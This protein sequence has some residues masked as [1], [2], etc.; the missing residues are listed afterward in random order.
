MAEY[1]ADTI[2]FE[3]APT[4]IRVDPSLNL[5]FGS[6]AGANTQ[7]SPSGL[8]YPFP[9]ENR[10]S[11]DRNGNG[12]VDCAFSVVFRGKIKADY[13]ENYTFRVRHDDQVWVF[14]NGTEVFNNYC[15]GE[16]DG[17]TIPMVAGEWV[18]IEIMFFNDRWSNDYLEVKWRSPS[19]PLQHIGPANLGCP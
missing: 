7:P 18:P 16:F 4:L 10:V 12:L 14:V 9:P 5:P 17:K 3:G 15:C 13:S 1:R 6:G 11:Q 2:R 19:T 8:P